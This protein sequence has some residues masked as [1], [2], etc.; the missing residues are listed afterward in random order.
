VIGD[1]VVIR[2]EVLIPKKTVI[3]PYKEVDSSIENEGSVI[4]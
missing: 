3:L 2:D 4:L 1:E